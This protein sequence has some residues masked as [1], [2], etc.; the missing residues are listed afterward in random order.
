M[1]DEHYTKY[2]ADGAPVTACPPGLKP[3]TEPAPR[4]NEMPSLLQHYQELAAE[5]E[6]NEKSSLAT[7]PPHVATPPH[8][9]ARMQ[10][11]LEGLQ[12]SPKFEALCRQPLP[13]PPSLSPP[14]SPQ[15]SPA[16]SPAKPARADSAVY[17]NQE[18]RHA[19][20]E[21]SEAA[22]ACR[23]EHENSALTAE[24][25]RFISGLDAAEPFTSRQRCAHELAC[26]LADS[27]GESNVLL[28]ERSW[29]I[30]F[31][32][33]FPKKLKND[34]CP[35]DYQLRRSILPHGFDR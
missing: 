23:P 13:A 19:E 20:H 18:A 6:A 14:E 2:S 17:P 25:Q 9:I 3:L 7:T 22:D 5:A 1:Q 11:Q 12:L 24:G 10:A 29:M 16:S 32:R 30:H 26:R 4:R 34:A 8:E 28:G 15:L 27:D 33:N 31:F 21:N 35:H